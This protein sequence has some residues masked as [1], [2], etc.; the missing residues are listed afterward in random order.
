MLMK[1]KDGSAGRA[2][3]QGIAAGLAHGVLDRRT[4]LRRS[5]L[6]AGAGA[7]IGLMPLG[8]GAQG[9]CRAEDRRR[10][11]GNQKEHLHAL[12]GRLHRHG[13][14][15]ERR[16]GRPGAGWES[17]INRGTHCAKGAAVREL[18]H[19]DRRLK[20]PMKLVNGEWQR[21][22]WD[23]G[24]REIADKLMEIRAQVG[25]RFRLSAGL[26][27]SSP[28]RARYLY[29]KFAAFWGT[30]SSTTRP[31]SATRPRSPVS[32]TPGATARRPT[33]TTTSATPRP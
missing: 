22:S 5:G 15:A 8:L 33:P 27:P 9:A 23:A 31:A 20:Y 28:T 14:S 24:D 18:V 17:P 13:R 3:L 21:I 6:A 32:P 11:D 29:R 2:R 19:G 10:T 16:L 30:N 4:F 12:L 7:A 1:R 26:A 25:R